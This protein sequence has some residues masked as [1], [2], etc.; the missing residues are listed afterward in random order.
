M[1]SGPWKSAPDGWDE[2]P[3]HD[4]MVQAKA[5]ALGALHAGEP[6]S[7]QERLAYF[8]DVRDDHAG[9]TF[10]QLEPTDPLHMT[11]CDLLATTLLSVR[12]GTTLHQTSP[13]GRADQGRP[14]W[15][16]QDDIRR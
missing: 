10:A 7:V 16:T 8:Y 2:P 6:N 12:I 13:P 4:L 14:N 11:P 15:Q 1:G 3:P 5:K 9:A